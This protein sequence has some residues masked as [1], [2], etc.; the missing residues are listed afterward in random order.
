MFGVA[1]P[2]KPHF[3]TLT[4]QF[5]PYAAYLFTAVLSL[6]ASSCLQLMYLCVYGPYAPG[7]A[8]RGCQILVDGSCKVYLESESD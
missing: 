3:F 1:T 4:I 7:T 5:T 8:T 2:S 6:A